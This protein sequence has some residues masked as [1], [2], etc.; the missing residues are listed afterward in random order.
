MP[1]C[2]HKP[3]K[4]MQYQI[5]E[6]NH[7]PV[8]KLLPLTIITGY[9]QWSSS[10]ENGLWIP[11]WTAHNPCKKAFECGNLT[12]TL[13]EGGESACKH[14]NSSDSP[15]QEIHKLG[16]LQLLPNKLASSTLGG[17]VS[18]WVS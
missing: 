2:L 17:G 16:T 15:S 8:S 9:K 7:F 12:A 6:E 10:S 14:C 5:V 1:S 13:T 18:E 3:S 11:V 4:P